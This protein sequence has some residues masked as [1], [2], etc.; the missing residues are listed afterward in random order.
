MGI[1]EIG[2][3]GLHCTEIIFN[4]YIT[5]HIRENREPRLEL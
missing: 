2:S 1:K 4:Q 5:M 3:S